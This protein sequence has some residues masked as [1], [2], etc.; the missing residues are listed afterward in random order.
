MY[1]WM[2]NKIPGPIPVRVLVV[3]AVAVAL[4]FLLM[5]VVYPAIEQ[6]MPFSDVAVR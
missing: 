2:W 5:N 3:I 1:G 6:I 4:F